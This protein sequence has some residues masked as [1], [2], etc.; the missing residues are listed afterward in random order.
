MK[1]FI[2]GLHS[3]GKQEVG[4]ILRDMDVSV[5]RL[6]TNLDEESPSIYNCNKY[7]IF[8]TQIVNELFENDSYIFIH[9]LET[10][11]GFVNYKTY[12]GMTMWEYD[13][14]DV[15]ILSPNQL[16]AIPPAKLRG[17]DICYV[18]L[19][20]T[21]EHRMSYYISRDCTYSFG[22]QESLETQDME[23]FVK[24]VYYPG[25]KV[26]YFT[27]ETPERIATI[28]YACIKHEDL[29]PIFLN[30]FNS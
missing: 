29:L 10:Q 25:S 30:N 24:K 19:D 3:S 27:N 14:N 4:Q 2:V 1:F 17:E 6:F 26:L 15:H 23:S 20:N 7:E 21:R 16:I 9:D 18:W 12:E 28:I 13:Q 5:G 22:F 11:I 8:D